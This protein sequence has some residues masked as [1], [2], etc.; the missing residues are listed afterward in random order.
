VRLAIEDNGIGIPPGQRRRIFEPFYRAPR[1]GVD[2]VQG[3][4]IGLSYV[5]RVVAGHGGS[6]KVRG[7]P[8]GGSVFEIALPVSAETSDARATSDD[9]S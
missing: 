9:A 8:N 4:G 1:G 3:F 6:I 5:A 2:D 7:G